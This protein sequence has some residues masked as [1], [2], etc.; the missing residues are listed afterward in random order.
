[1]GF[2]GSF[3]YRFV[4]RFLW[5]IGR[6]GDRLRTLL[7]L[8]AIGLGVGVV[9]AIEL[10]NQSAIHSFQSSLLE[11]SG[12]TNLSILG[13]HGIDEMWLPQLRQL[14][15]P[16]VQLSPLIESTAVI[17]STQEVLRVLGMDIVQDRP[18]RDTALRETPVSPRQFLLLLVDPRSVVVG[19]NLA[20][21]YQLEPG[22]RIALLVNDRQEEFTVRGILALQGPGQALAGNLVIMDIAAAQLAFARL[23]RVD[24]VDLIVPEEKLAAYEASLPSQLPAGLRVE[25][26]EARAAQTE[27]MLR[28][29]RWNLTALGY[30]SLVVGAFLIYNTI[31]ISVVR[32]RAEIGALRA[33]GAT[34]AQVLRLFLG[35]AL[36]L[37]AMGG[38]L[39]IALGR[40]LAGLALRF[41]SATVNALY[42]A[43]P[44]APVQLDL[45]MAFL[46]VA[47][48]SVT[49]LVSALLPAM[50]ATG[51]LPAEALHHG[52]HEH[53]HGLAL[54]RYAAVGAGL[55]ALAGGAA[56]LPSLV[57]VASVAGLP[58]FGY[59]AALLVVVGCSFLMPLLVVQFARLLDRPVQTLA[60]I[61]GRLAA[62]GLAGSPARIAVLTMAL[63]TAVAMMASVAIMV[64]SFRHTVQV[65]A[66]QTLRADLFLRPAAQR[67][68]ASDARIAP[69]IVQIV[70]ATEGV[71]AVDAF[72]GLDILYDGKPAVLGAGD[73]PVLA[74][75]GNLLFLDGRS[76]A[77]VLA[78]NSS[79]RAIVSEPFAIHHKVGS[80]QTVQLD[81]PSGKASFEVA[82]IYYDYTNDRG[83]ILL[84]R[85]AYREL[86][87]DDTASALA[88]YLRPD[89]ADELVR[90]ELGGRLARQ[91]YQLLIVPNAALQQVVLRVFDR[92]FA[93]TYALEVVAILVAALGIGN[94]LLALTLERRRELG[95]L[96][97]L[98]CTRSQVRKLI[99]TEATL[100]GVLGNLVG[101]AMGLLLS[102]ILIF[103]INKQSFGWT[104]QFVYPWGFLAGAGL[105]I[106]LVTIVAGLYPARVAA[107][108]V[109]AEAVWIE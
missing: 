5:G 92:T 77:E 52:A 96:R 65:W 27:T 71:E 54:R 76:A 69:E 93:I 21:R 22:S 62:R 37:G 67:A 100:V 36:L 44:P 94:A 95:I 13:P 34:R 15:D 3:F 83:T 45:S 14:A 43:A 41:I 49:A 57:S 17:A 39:G 1:M 85:K 9:L 82:G 24:R 97:I 88:V 48:G 35:E 20:R 2:S 79:R 105:A 23:G 7:S 12:R 59:L 56:Y 58:L 70:R 68:G 86:F 16:D 103:V 30:I 102:L 63:A 50:E 6:S 84:D 55:L 31:A 66:S 47:I 38:L 108:L 72:R 99:L 33:L 109:P 89:A 107:R 98:G 80:G 87:H 28:A 101:W 32:R 60:G 73:W 90:A 75:Y 18:F 53:R 104:I 42:L 10:A 26:P 106:W 25:R 91:G 19:E 81:T 40:V 78:G 46:A 29:F 51:V 4:V 8:V 64:G 61:E 11:I 74:R